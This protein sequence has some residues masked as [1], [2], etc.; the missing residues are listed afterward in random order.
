MR[1]G[2][3]LSLPLLLEIF[4]S[5]FQVILRQTETRAVSELI[6]VLSPVPP[7]T[8]RRTPRVPYIHLHIAGNMV[9]LKTGGL[10]I[11][12]YLHPSDRYLAGR[13]ITVFWLQLMLTC[14][15]PQVWISTWWLVPQGRFSPWLLK[16]DGV[17]YPK[18]IFTSLVQGSTRE[19]NVSYA[20]TLLF[21]AGFVA[22][23]GK[24]KCVE[25][26]GWEACRKY[27]TSKTCV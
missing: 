3:N 27:A 14:A 18:V 4:C 19:E 7:L 2:R 12:R 24:E 10:V 6:D 5:V 21:G 17:I 15:R 8:V 23:R 26:F 11:P 25:E 9:T 13:N 16:C 22:L 20:Y 1:N